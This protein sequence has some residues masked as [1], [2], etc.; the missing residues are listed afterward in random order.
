MDNN[1][2]QS[3]LI[4]GYEQQVESS[5]RELSLS[6]RTGPPFPSDGV[7]VYCSARTRA[8]S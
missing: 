6:T 4:L 5:F 2:M 3:G 1:Y 8:T 7:D